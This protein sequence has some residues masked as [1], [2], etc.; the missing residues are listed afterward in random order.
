MMHFFK[1]G[2]DYERIGFRKWRVLK[3]FDTVCEFRPPV[4]KETGLISPIKT[5]F[6]L[7]KPDG[8]LNIEKGFQWDGAT[9][10]W[11]TDSIMKG[12]CVHDWFCN[13]VDNGVLPVSYR[14][15]GD[16]LFKRICL[17]EGMPEFR[18]VY[19]H[20]AVVAWGKL[21]HNTD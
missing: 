17:E 18:A 15:K 21:K 14:R 19:A 16:D 20:A 12:S 13:A 11:D 4:C 6:G 10:A 7:F 8:V 1:D 9:F 2:E 5:E 3:A